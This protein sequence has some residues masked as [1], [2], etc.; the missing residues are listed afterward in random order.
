M[1]E[2][3]E[4][5]IPK[6]EKRIEI[7]IAP[8]L[9]TEM[10]AKVFEDVSVMHYAGFTLATLRCATSTPSPSRPRSSLSS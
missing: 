6:N 3:G 7:A 10:R 8:Q 2:A 4:F 1:D 9:M 5:H